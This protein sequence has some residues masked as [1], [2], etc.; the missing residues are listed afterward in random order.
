MAADTVRCPHCGIVL[1]LDKTV[2]GK[3]TLK[4]DIDEWRQ[5]CK[6]RHLGSPAL[7]LVERDDTGSRPK[8]K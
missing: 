5:L 6:H 7:C 1:T 8:R 2:T 3:N 4:Y